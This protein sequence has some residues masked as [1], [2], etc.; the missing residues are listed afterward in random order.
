MPAIFVFGDSLADVG[1]NNYL[2]T[3]T[4]KADFPHNGIDFPGSTPTGRFSNGYNIID[5]LG[6][7]LLI[8]SYLV[9]VCIISLAILSNSKANIILTFTLAISA[10][11]VGYKQSSPAFLTLTNVTQMLRGVNFASG[12][13]G[14]LDNTVSNAR[15]YDSYRLHH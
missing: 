4:A 6:T 11:F 8:A 15:I 2:N 7:R 12:G 10:K 5:S 13:A 14:I 1:N 9:P 3:S